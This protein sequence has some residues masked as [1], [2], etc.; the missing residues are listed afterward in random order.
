MAKSEMAILMRCCSK[1][2]LQTAVDIKAHG[3][4]T[5]SSGSRQHFVS[6]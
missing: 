1:Q 6:L 5:K 3:Y 2:F 4:D